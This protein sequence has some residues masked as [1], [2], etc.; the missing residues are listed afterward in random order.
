MRRAPVSR[1]GK[2]GRDEGGYV[3]YL[4]AGLL[5]VL[6]ALAGFGVDLGIWFTQAQD[7]QAAVDAAALAGVVYMPGDFATASSVATSTLAKNG[8]VAG[9]DGYSVNISPVSGYPQRLKVC[10]TD[11]DVETF[12]SNVVG[13]NPTISKCATAEYVL[14]V[15]MGSPLNV[16]DKT[17]L[18]VNPAVNGYCTAKEDGDLRLSRYQGNRPS[19]G[20]AVCVGTPKEDNA[21][22][23]ASAYQY[24]VEVPTVP[25]SPIAVQVYDGSFMGSGD[26]LA[27]SNNPSATSNIT[28]TF[29]VFDSTLTPLD[30][31]DDPVVATVTAPSRNATW[32][33]VWT[34]IYTIP[35]GSTVGRYR[36]Q[37]STVAGELNSAG[38]NAF[39][40]RARVGGSF[41]QCSTIPGDPGYSAS[42]P[43]VFAISELSVYANQAGGTANFYLADVDAVHAGKQMVIQLFDPGEGARTIEVL[44]PNGNPVSFDYEN[45][46][47]FTPTYSGTTNVLDVSGTGPQP[48]NRSSTFKFNERKMQL[49]IDI[50]ANYAA[51]FGT[52]T[53]WKL[54]YTTLSTGVTDRTTWSVSII[55]DPLRLV[56]N[57]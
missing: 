37:S 31:S 25:A 17:T 20:G 27:L 38:V 40:L 2:H 12:F 8:V 10:A 53:W 57:A 55:G 24:A 36:V 4:T 32:D 50:P 48:P 15:S 42:C 13:A 19:G 33:N 54:R 11:S 26:D 46:E 7:A 14:P 3:L 6:L 51:A 23:D 56:P 30:S 39:G 52:R 1:R 22:Y 35:A 16:F 29:T 21:D 43:Q 41:S 45:V 34:T 5:T 28:T 47:G 9:S 44:D 18:G 49:T